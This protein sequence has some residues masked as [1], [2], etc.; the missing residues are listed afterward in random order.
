MRV[1]YC[2]P[3]MY[4]PGEK[5][6][7]EN[8]FQGLLKDKWV[9]VFNAEYSNYWDSTKELLKE[10]ML[11]NP[12][13]IK[14]LNIFLG[15]APYSSLGCSTIAFDESQL[16][17]ILSEYR[18]GGAQIIGT[19]SNSDFES[20]KREVAVTAEYIRQ[21]KQLGSDVIKCE[22]GRPYRDLLVQSY[23]ARNTAITSSIGQKL[24]AKGYGLLMLG[25]IHFYDPISV[26]N[27]I[28]QEFSDINTVTI[29]PSEKIRFFSQIA[30]G[31][32]LY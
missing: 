17:F 23:R 6:L 9:N 26:V 3:L 28:N 20:F 1:L 12:A 24:P 2:L 22:Q 13:I 25:M 4:N 32:L 5:A 18:N 30:I 14:K 19:E 7:I 11:G 16:T 21:N 8:L 15:G 29:W 27:R 31:K 10:T